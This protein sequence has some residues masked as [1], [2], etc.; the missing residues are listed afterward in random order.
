MTGLLLVDKN[1]KTHL[2]WHAI[3]KPP[4]DAGR[5]LLQW[6]QEWEEKQALVRVA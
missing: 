2:V 3:D 4:K 1:G 6:I 5:R